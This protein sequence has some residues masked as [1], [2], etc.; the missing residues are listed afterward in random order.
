MRVKRVVLHGFKTFAQK[1]EFIFDPGI[2]AIVGPNG[3]GK[4]NVA[5]G[6]RWCLGEQSFSLLR[7]KKTADVIFSGSDKRARLGMASVN[8]ILDNSQGE[9]AIDFDEVEISRRAYRDGDNE[10]L[11]NGQ[12]VRLLDVNELLAP[13][14]LG[15]RTYAVIGQGLIDRVLSLKPEERRSLFEEAAG[16]TGYQSKRG[17]TLRRLD[18]T[19]LNLTRIQDIVAE[20]SPRLKYMRRQADRYSEYVQIEA[21]LRDQ[22]REWYGFRWHSQLAELSAQQEIEAGLRRSVALRQEAVDGVRGELLAIRQRQTE[23]R[24]DVGDLHGTSSDL[25]RRADQVGRELAVSRERARQLQVR[26]DETEREIAEL[27]SRRQTAEQRAID[28]AE[29]LAAAQSAH[30]ARQER[31]Q[32]LQVI[33]TAHQADRQSLLEQ[34]EQTRRRATTL[35]NRTTERSSQL[36]QAQARRATLTNAQKEQTQ[37]GA[38]AQAE[39]ERVRQEL[40]QAQSEVSQNESEA[41][42]LQAEIRPLEDETK[43]LQET[44]AQAEQARQAADRAVDRLQTR[45][46]LLERLRNEGAGYASGVKAVLQ[47]GTDGQ[48]DDPMLAGI[49]GTVASLIRVPAHLDKA[50]ETALGGA[51]QNVVTATWSDSREAI[52]FLKRTGRG[53]ATFLPLD[54]LHVPNALDAP[55][56]P[57]ILGNAA[58]LVEYDSRVE[59]AALQLL[60]RT[61]IATDLAAARS[62]LDSIRGS[63]PRPTL[64]T[65]DGEIVRPGGAV[66]G[67][68]DSRRRDD[69][70]LARERE[71]R[72]LP[73]QI[74]SAQA[75]GKENAG[76]CRRLAAQLEALGVQTLAAQENLAALVRA[77]RQRRERVEEVRRR[78]DR[79]EQSVRWQSDLHTRSSAELAQLADQE[80]GLTAE[81]A[82]LESEVAEAA[83]ALTQAETQAEAS[84]ADDLL[85]QMAELKTAAAEALGHLRSRQSLLDDQ[86]SSGQFTHTQ[87]Q[88]KSSHQADLDNS[89]AELTRQIATLTEKE[90]QLNLQIEELGAKIDPG[91]RELTQLEQ[92]R[93]GAEQRE[94]ALQQILRRDE[95]TFNT[96]QLKLQRCEDGLGILR[97][98]IEHDFGLVALEQS[99]ALADQPP[100]PLDSMVEH[101][102]VVHQ[103]PE[104]MEDEVREMRAR[105]QR[106]GNVNPEALHEYE[107]ASTRHEFLLSQSKDLEAAAADMRKII[108]E[109][110]QRMSV[111]FDSTFRAVDK[112][113]VEFF[114]ILFNGGTA[115]LS[116]TDPEDLTNTGIEIVARPPGKRP[117][118]LAL[119]SGGERSMTALA[120]IFAILRVSPTPF[121]ILD[122]VDA[123]LD[124]ANVD[125]FRDAL[126]SLS[127]E[128][129]F[130]LITHN[131]RTLETADTIYGITM[132]GDG[133]S[134]VISLRLDGDKIV[135]DDGGNDQDAEKLVEGLVGV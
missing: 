39:A 67:G 46:D 109:L 53:R 103:L 22:L 37:A 33:L 100:L 11:V 17:T 64:V 126:R 130:I 106:L 21:D 105:L 101:L 124:E 65:Q 92:Q 110:D 68:E 133:V 83:I 69:S 80:A 62:A 30:N 88:A 96:A 76:I 89:L 1:T 122:E 99:D 59:S 81:L 6:V 91:E 87:I 56:L 61:W 75:V 25:H 102:P 50:I 24:A 78:L 38:T 127:G 120:L 113:F 135:R 112:E 43:G 108:A 119:L 31:V 7:S 26:R 129:Q 98:E 85:Q 117:Q 125:R 13:S 58:D 74:Q 9:M 32:A 52:D 48:Q 10:Y 27:S 73:G 79:A 19:Q 28:L 90:A 20:I 63:G 49:L 18:A 94:Q 104:G 121:C 115:K 14:G 8:V 84:R 134:K 118:S 29:E 93:T 16:I 35:Q 23:L 41:A 44:L 132:G 97:R 60:N 2:T 3:S 82:T 107:E 47:A 57:G 95:A 51:L 55:N 71:F 15:N 72:E 36:A 77:D 128:T 70:M 111:A 12:K 123:A 66:T 4:S 131:R 86:R 114:K 34:V 5:D 42:D 116:L 40:A 45:L 54:R